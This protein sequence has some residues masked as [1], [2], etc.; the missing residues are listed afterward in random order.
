[1]G[2]EWGSRF[3]SQIFFVAFWLSII[4]LILFCDAMASLSTDSYSIKSMPFFEGSLKIVEN[5][6]TTRV[7]YYAGIA[8]M[9]FRSCDGDQSCPP[10]S[11]GWGDDSC[12]K[13]FTN[14]NQCRDAP[15]KVS[16]PIVM[17]LLGQIGQIAT[18]LNRS[19]GTFSQPISDATPLSRLVYLTSYEL[20]L[21]SLVTVKYDL[22]CQ[23]L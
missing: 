13:Y 6:V 20:V 16:F 3:R 17:S 1:M 22:H 7:D 23:K 2:T 14:C 10:E 19:T 12:D 15:A 21:F 8:R 11:L 9:V 18:D 5:N 4:G